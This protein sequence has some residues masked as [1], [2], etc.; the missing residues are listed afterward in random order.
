MRSGGV[1]AGT[2]FNTINTFLLSIR[3]GGSMRFSS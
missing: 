1:S 3:I 2:T